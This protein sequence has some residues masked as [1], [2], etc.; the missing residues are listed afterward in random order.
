[1]DFQVCNCEVGAPVTAQ[2]APPSVELYIGPPYPVTTATSFAPSA[3]EAT[4]HQFFVG[5]LLEDQVSPELVEV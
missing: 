1:M 4:E 5:T 2:L 3:E